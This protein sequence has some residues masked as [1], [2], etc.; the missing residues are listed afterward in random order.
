MNVE[1]ENTVQK[2]NPGF[3]V[4]AVFTCIVLL[5]ICGGLLIFRSYV[6]NKEHSAEENALFNNPPTVRYD[7][8]V[9]R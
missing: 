4:G 8:S 1:I 7:E 5:V 3:R 2:K 9:P 6:I